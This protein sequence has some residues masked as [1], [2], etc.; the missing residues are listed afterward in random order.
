MITNWKAVLATLVLSASMFGAGAA[1]TSS[2]QA[3][4]IPAWQRGGYGSDR[5]LRWAESR[6]E[7]LIGQLSR[8]QHDYDG[9]R[10]AALNDLQQARVQ[11]QQAINYD[12]GHGR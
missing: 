1:L 3:Q 2:A 5:N 7:Q 8:D 6:V 10:V 9:H 4:T 12:R 11:L